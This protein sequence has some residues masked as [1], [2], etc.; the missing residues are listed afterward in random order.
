M[1]KRIYFTCILSWWAF[2][3]QRSIFLDRQREV[4]HKQRCLS[5][6]LS[7]DLSVHGSHYSNGK[8]GTLS[9]TLFYLCHFFTEVLPRGH[10]MPNT[11]DKYTFELSP[12]SK[13]K[14]WMWNQM[15]FNLLVFKAT[16]LRV[17]NWRNMSSLF[18]QVIEQIYFLQRFNVVFIKEDTGHFRIGIDMGRYSRLS[19]K[20]DLSIKR[21]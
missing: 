16:Q 7:F 21:A 17:D 18:R 14:M 12:V 11:F 3:E 9:K 5:L 8:C 15:L 2:D 13:E 1:W 19:F 10:A 20:K 6:S 4:E